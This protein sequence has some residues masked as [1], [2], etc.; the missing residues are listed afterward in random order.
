MSLFSWAFALNWAFTLD[1]YTWA[2]RER[3]RGILALMLLKLPTIVGLQNLPLPG[4]I[5]EKNT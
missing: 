5:V 2:K 4:E 1:L 3:S